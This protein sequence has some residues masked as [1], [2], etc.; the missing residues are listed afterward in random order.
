MG[1]RREEKKKERKTKGSKRF[2]QIRD[3]TYTNTYRC[4]ETQCRPNISKL[5]K[6]Y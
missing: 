3:S 5:Y 1:Q 2:I 4:E 6:M